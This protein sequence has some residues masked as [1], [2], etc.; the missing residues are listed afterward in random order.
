MNAKE[1]TKI[2]EELVRTKKL[3]YIDAIVYYCDENEI[4]TSTVN[5]IITKSIKDKIRVEAENLN[6]LPKT[7][8]LPG[9]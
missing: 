5:T 6:Y 1:F 2:I 9:V 7:S 3:S 4:D 8:R